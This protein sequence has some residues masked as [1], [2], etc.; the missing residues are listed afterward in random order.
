MYISDYNFHI[1]IF[2][3]NLSHIYARKLKS[4]SKT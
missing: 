3:R 1:Y 4:H 2:A